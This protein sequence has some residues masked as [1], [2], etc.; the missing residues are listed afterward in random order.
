VDFY[1]G[2][3][4]RAFSIL[5]CSELKLTAPSRLALAQ[6]HDDSTMITILTGRPARGVKNRVKREIG[7]ISLNVPAMADAA[8]VGMRRLS[9]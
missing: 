5:R 9:S 4:A 6:A 7:P 2:I 3:E 1:S 8:L